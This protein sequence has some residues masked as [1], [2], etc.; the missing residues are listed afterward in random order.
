MK[1]WVTYIAALAMGFATALLFKDI[2]GIFGIFMN[3]FYFGVNLS[4]ALFIPI[5]LITFSSG[6]ASLKKDQVG[7]KLSWGLIGWAVIT[8]VLLPLVAV[9]VY[10]LFPTNFPVTSTAGTDTSS[11]K[12]IIENKSLSALSQLY[13][14]NPFRTLSYASTFLLPVII[15]AWILGLSLKP[16]SDVIRPAYTVVNSFAEVMYRITRTATVIGSAFAYF[17]STYFFLYLYREKTLLVSKRFLAVTTSSTFFVLL[18]I[19]PLL[20]ALITGF[21]KNPYSVIGNS[22]SS[23]SLALVTG[24][25]LTADLVGESISRQNGGAQKRAVSV[26]TPVFT[27]IGRGGTGFVSTLSSLMLLEAITGAEVSLSISMV[28]AAM[29]MIVTF[30]SS[31]FIGYEIIAIVYLTLSYLKINTYGAEIAIVALLPFL[32]GLGTMLDSAINNMASIIASF[33]IGTDIKVPYSETI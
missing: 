24:N 11:I 13:P 6:V 26:T 10:K 33:F 27:I 16:S 21:R 30:S 2:N 15:I 12:S 9:A 20:Y 19:L 32:S 28:I 29:T 17:A 25:I 1:T 4:I 23:L 3:I 8:S 22:V 14:S 18:I 31:A 7:S 5:V